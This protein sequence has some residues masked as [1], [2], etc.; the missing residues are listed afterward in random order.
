[1]GEVLHLFEAVAHGQ[2]MR[3]ADEVTAMVNKGFEH[4]IHGRLGN[5]RQVLLMDIETL[6]EFGIA[7]GRVKENVTTR[8]LDLR[9][10]GLGQRLSAGEAILEIAKPCEPCR[11]IDEIRMGYRE[12]MRGRRGVLCRVIQGGRIRRGD[13]IEMG[14]RALGS[15]AGQGNE[16]GQE[17]IE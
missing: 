9:G 2:P 11:H 1:M 14:A 17:A 12:A 16:Q 7:P 5:S 10:L 15:G 3:E 6:G 13:R 8:G 4:C